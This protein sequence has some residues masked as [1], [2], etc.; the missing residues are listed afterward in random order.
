MV[1]VYQYTR[2]NSQLNGHS[3][4]P[5]WPIGMIWM[6]VRFGNN[7]YVVMFVIAEHLI[8][9]EVIGTEFLN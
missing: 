3:A 9:E 4:K 7:H 5:F 8:V 1:A 2:E 6:T